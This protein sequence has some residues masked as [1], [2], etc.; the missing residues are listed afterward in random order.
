MVKNRKRRIKK[1]TYAE[2]LD[3]EFTPYLL[4]RKVPD[5]EKA[6][7]FKNFKTMAFCQS[8]L[9]DRFFFLLTHQGK[10]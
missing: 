9:R 5:I 6:I 7:F 8:S 10:R 4:V 3:S 1:A 2:K